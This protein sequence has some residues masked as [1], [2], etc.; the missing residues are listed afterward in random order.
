MSDPVEIGLSVFLASVA[1]YNAFIMSKV[2][3]LVGDVNLGLEKATGAIKE[4][5]RETF[6]EKAAAEKIEQRVHDL[7]QRPVRKRSAR[8]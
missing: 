3:N 2:K 8:G 1:G 4:W 7:E 5:A 6:A